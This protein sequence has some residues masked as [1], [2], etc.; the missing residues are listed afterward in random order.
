[1]SFLSKEIPCFSGNLNQAAVNSFSQENTWK[2][3]L[4]SCQGSTSINTHSERFFVLA[5]LAAAPKTALHLLIRN[6][7]PAASQT[8]L[9]PVPLQETLEEEVDLAGGFLNKY[10]ETQHADFLI[11]THAGNYA[12]SSN[13]GGSIHSNSLC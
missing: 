9:A 10:W 12:Q 3:L 1:M 6:G 4:G 5:N 11:N 13:T 7:F 8:L 2:N